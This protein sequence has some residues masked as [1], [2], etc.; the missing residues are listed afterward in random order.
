MGAM[1]TVQTLT[2]PSSYVHMS[3][4]PTATK[5]RRIPAAG[6]LVTLSDVSQALNLGSGQQRYNSVVCAA[7]RIFFSSSSSVT[8]PLVLSC[9]CSLTSVCI[10]PN[11]SALEIARAHQPIRQEESKAAIGAPRWDGSWVRLEPIR[12]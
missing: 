6:S 1:E 11:E 7:M 12:W 9:C 10:P 8:G 2:W 5:A 4:K 3:T